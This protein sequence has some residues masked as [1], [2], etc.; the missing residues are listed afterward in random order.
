MLGEDN[1]SKIADK[2]NE[3]RAKADAEATEKAKEE[4]AAIIAAKNKLR[5]QKLNSNG[6]IK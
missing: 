5:L 3:L 1:R 6:Q 4:K 2:L